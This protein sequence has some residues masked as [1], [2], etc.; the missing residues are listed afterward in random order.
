MQLPSAVGRGRRDLP[1]SQYQMNF[2]RLP[3]TRAFS[4]VSVFLAVALVSI[5]ALLTACGPSEVQLSATSAYE[6]AE[7]DINRLRTTAT[8]AR[9]RLQIT[10][11]YVGTRVMQVEQA[12]QFLRSGLMD[13]GTESAFIDANLSQLQLQP[14]PT[15]RQGLASV[16][17][18]TATPLTLLAGSNAQRVQVA[19]ATAVAITPDYRPRL[20]KVVLASRVDAEDC[21]LDINP[22]FTPE[23]A[24]IYIVARAFNI[25]AGANLSSIWQR[26]GTEVAQLS[27]QTE[28]AIN[29]NCI[30]FF[31]DQSD[32]PF[33]A[34]AWSV[35]IRL[36][37]EALMSPL[38]FRVVPS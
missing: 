12:N 2:W 18:A 32:T 11:D 27:F 16:T 30:W 23:S 10:L 24:A 15:Q 7:T 26:Q 25:P 36:D 5:A 14:T 31:I 28:F 29:D 34:G 8:V 22:L 38:P 20:G 1:R 9:A 6:I 19:A 33:L 4:A 37:G 17:G 35:E 13:L 21:A 3:L